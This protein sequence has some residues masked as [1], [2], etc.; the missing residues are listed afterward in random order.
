MLSKAARRRFFV[1]VFNMVGCKSRLSLMNRTPLE[2]SFFSS[3]IDSSKDTLGFLAVD[4]CLAEVMTSES[5]GSLVAWNIEKF[6]SCGA[7][8]AAVGF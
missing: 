4:Y 6:P 3:P 8:V 1:L 2:A 7:E 5:A